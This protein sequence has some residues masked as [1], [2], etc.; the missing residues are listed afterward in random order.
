VSR[1]ARRSIASFDSA[2]AMLRAVARF[3][4][5]R[6]MPALGSVPRPLVPIAERVVPLVNLLPERPREAV[7][8]FGSGREAVPPIAWTRSTARPSRAG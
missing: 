5:D 2:T 6:D 4:H 1:P 8:A 7:Y 3:L